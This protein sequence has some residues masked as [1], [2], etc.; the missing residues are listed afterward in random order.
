VAIHDQVAEAIAAA[1]RAI[2]HPESLDEVLMQ[3]ATAARD[4]LPAFDLVGVSMLEGKNVVTRAATD[5]RVYE[6]DQ[7][8][9]SEDEGPCVDTLGGAHLVVAP[10]LRH[11]QRWPRYVPKALQLG[12]RS[13][14]AV[15]LE[16]DDTGTLGGLN[17]YSTLSDDV[18][19]EAA[20]IAELFARHAATAL[21]G[22]RHITNL[23]QALQSRKIIGQAQGILMERYQMTEERAFAFLVR[24]SSTSNL[25]VLTIA[26]ELVSAANTRRVRGEADQG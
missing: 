26:Q 24:A 5:S 18:D 25:K 8:Q 6:L 9:Y 15:K 13:Q 23:N 17:M 19:P 22:A 14:L 7:L 20:S 1:A 2:H 16:L 12:L 11:E 4:S 21:G 10:R 3:I